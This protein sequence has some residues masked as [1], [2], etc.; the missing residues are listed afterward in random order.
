MKL[1]AIVILFFAAISANAL[2]QDKCERYAETPRYIN[3]IKAVASHTMRDMKELCTLPSIWDIEAQPDR[4]ITREGE[5]VPH[6][7]VQLH[8]EYDSCLYMVRDYD[9]AITE[10]RCYS[11]Y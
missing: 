10:A 4:R 2:P 3:A 9:K 1:I 7:R 6:V 5:I 8:R 11:G